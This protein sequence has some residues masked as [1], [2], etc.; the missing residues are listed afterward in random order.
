MR[1]IIAILLSLV[2]VS[3]AQAE[4]VRGYT[5]RDGRYVNGY[6]RSNRNNTV[7]DNYSYRGNVNPYTGKRGTNSYNS[8]NPY[9]SSRTDRNTAWGTSNSNN[10]NWFD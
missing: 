3:S 8:Y 6:Y 9:N 2:L 4:W 7:T 5:R 10:N 1:Y